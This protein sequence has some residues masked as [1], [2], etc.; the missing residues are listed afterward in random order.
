MNK[1]KL[2]LNGITSIT[3]QCTPFKKTFCKEQMAFTSIHLVFNGT[4][5][6][7]CAHGSFGSKNHDWYLVFPYEI[8]CKQ[9]KTVCQV[10]VKA[11]LKHVINYCTTLL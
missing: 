8:L 9:D 10:E 1:K 3:L 4:I 5:R 6:F 7:L 2:C 11:M